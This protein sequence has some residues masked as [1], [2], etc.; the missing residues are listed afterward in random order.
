MSVPSSGCERFATSPN[1]LNGPHAAAEHSNLLRCMSLLLAL[2]RHGAMSEL[3]P[4]CAIKRTSKCLG[5]I[6]LAARLRRSPKLH[7]V[8]GANL[9]DH[10][11]GGS[12]SQTDG[13]RLQQGMKAVDLTGSAKVDVNLCGFPWGPR[14][15]SV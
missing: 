8:D 1:S 7:P 3:S 2:F 13:K 6:Y 4:L 12:K 14:G 5:M 11:R 9:R 15:P 10:I